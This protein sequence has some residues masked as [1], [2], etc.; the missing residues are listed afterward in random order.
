[1]I[2]HRW[3]PTLPLAATVLAMALTAGC[4][5]D[6]SCA[7]KSYHPDLGQ[8]GAATPIDALNVWLGG[9]TGYGDDLPPDDSWIVSEPD[10]HDT[11]V[12][13]IR[14]DDGDGWWVSV[15]KTESGGWVVAEATDD[16]TGCAD[17][18]SG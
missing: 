15:R 2:S 3:R 7:G 1:M 12:T 14:N 13:V 18:L 17:E 16:A 8:K 4:S 9:T 5:G 11:T 10:P 6:D